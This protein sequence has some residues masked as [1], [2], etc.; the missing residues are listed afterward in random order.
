[1]EKV[2]EGVTRP[3]F[4]CP[5]STIERGIISIWWVV[6]IERGQKI[7]YFLQDVINR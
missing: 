5:L 2:K 1:M 4:G 6:D 7:D 3:K